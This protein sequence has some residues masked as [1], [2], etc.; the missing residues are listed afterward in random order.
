M[1]RSAVPKSLWMSA[2]FVVEESLRGF[3]RGKLFVIPGWRYKLVVAGMKLLPAPLL[4]K[5]VSR[6]A[7]RMRR[8]LRQERP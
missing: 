5:I 1:D 7:R 3:D 4:R 6:G 2:D 8:P